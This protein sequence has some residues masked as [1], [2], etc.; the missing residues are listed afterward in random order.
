V[1]GLLAWMFYA[2]PT[3]VLAGLTV[4]HTCEYMAKNKRGKDPVYSTQFVCTYIGLYGSAPYIFSNIFST[5]A[6][7]AG[8][9]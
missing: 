2:P 8:S 6:R 9:L 5:F 1:T 7:Y 3:A 4:I